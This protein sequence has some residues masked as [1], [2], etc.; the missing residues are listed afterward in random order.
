MRTEFVM[1]LRN[2]QKIICVERSTL[3]KNVQ[4][5]DFRSDCVVISILQNGKL[6]N[7]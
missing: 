5:I 7:D 6:L 2:R 4:I 3:Q 1:N